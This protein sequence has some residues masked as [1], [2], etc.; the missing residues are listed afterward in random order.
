MLIKAFVF[1]CRF[2]PIKRLMWRRWYQILAKHRWEAGWTFMNYGFAPTAAALALHPDD[3]PNRHFIQLYHFVAGAINLRGLRVL[4]VGSGRGG[5][6]AFMKKYLGPARVTGTD[7]SPNAV[8]LCR[9]THC[10]DGLDFKRGDAESLPFEAGTFDAVVNVESSHCYGS[11]PAFL[12]EV[13]RVLRPGGHFLYADMRDGEAVPEWRR[14]LERSGMSILRE[15]DITPNVV[16]ALDAEDERKRGLIA[17]TIPGF[18][19]P[20]FVDFAGLRGSQVYEAFRTRRMVYFAYTLR[21]PA[22]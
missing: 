3:E 18:M 7:I 22:A 13:R 4:E 9:R 11:M 8:E 14:Q 12:A 17:K 6:A 20:A 2:A 5:G 21:S 10:V 19:Q 1:L 16:S 15:V